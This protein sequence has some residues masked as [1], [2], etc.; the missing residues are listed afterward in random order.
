MIKLGTIK[1]NAKGG[2]GNWRNER[3]T[4]KQRKH[5]QN[6][7]FDDN[8]INNMSKGDA[9][10]ELDKCFSSDRENAES[11]REILEGDPNWGLD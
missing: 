9:S 8:E 4:P 2:K 10:D 1:H 6:F 3:V 11:Q 7:G 5:L